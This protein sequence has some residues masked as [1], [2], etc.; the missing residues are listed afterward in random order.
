MANVTGLI[1]DIPIPGSGIIA[2]AI[3]FLTS[4]IKGKTTHATLS[5]VNPAEQNYRLAIVAAFSNFTTDEQ[6]LIA[7]KAQPLLL[8]AMQTRWGLAAQGQPALASYIQTDGASISNLGGAMFS[9][10]AVNIDA[11]S[12]SEMKTVMDWAWQYVFVTAVQQANL[13]TSRI[14]GVTTSSKGTT[15]TL[16]T[17]GF[18]SSTIILVVVVLAILFAIMQRK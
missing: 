6:L 18:N 1:K 17:A 10:I 16:T 12:A 9:W 4:F 13:D 3:S 7:Q 8:S 11:A 15:S 2:D 5:Q 14:A